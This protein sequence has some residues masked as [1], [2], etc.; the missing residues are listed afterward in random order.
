[1][2][3]RY[4]YDSRLFHLERATLY[5]ISVPVFEKQRFAMFFV[6]VLSK[7]HQWASNKC[8]NQV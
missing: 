5:D 2:W 4:K 8:M 7:I 3:E 1:M 6:F